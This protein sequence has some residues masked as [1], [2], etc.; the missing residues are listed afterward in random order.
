MNLSVPEEVDAELTKELL[1][2][3][4]IQA[5]GSLV[6]PLCQSSSVHAEAFS[7]SIFQCR[8]HMPLQG[9]S[10]AT[11]ISSS[12]ADIRRAGIQL[13]SGALKVST[14]RTLSGVLDA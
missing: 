11:D 1:Q 4:D 7:R 14:A 2:K 5:A 13:L 3:Y 12:D 9:L 6:R 8:L 10:K